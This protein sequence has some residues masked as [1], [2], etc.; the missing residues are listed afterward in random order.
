MSKP[1]RVF[2]RKGLLIPHSRNMRA[3]WN[4]YKRGHRQICL[5][6]N[7][8]CGKTIDLLLYAIDKMRKIPNFRVN[9]YRTEYSTIATTV[10]ETMEHDVFEYPLGDSRNRHPKNPFYLSGGIERP[11]RLVWDNGSSMRFIGLDDKK[12]TRGMAADLSILNEGTRELT[13]EAWVEMGAIQAAGRAGAWIVDGEPFSQRILDTNPDSPLHWI[14][15]LFRKDTNTDTLPDVGTYPLGEKLWLGFST[16]DNP[17]HTDENGV[18]NAL[19]RKKD[20]DLIKTYPEGFERLRMVYSQW[21]AALGLVYSGYK[22]DVYEIDM[23]PKDFADDSTWYMGLDLGGTDPFA[24]C[25]VNVDGDGNQKLFREIFLSQC[26]LDDIETRMWHIIRDIIGIGQSELTIVSD[27]NVPEF[28]QR[29]RENGWHVIEAEKG[30]GS[31]IDRVDLGKK[32]I[33]A[34]KLRVAKDSLLER[35]PNYKGP[36]GFKEEVLGYAYHP[37]EKQELLKNPNL[38]IDKNDHS[39]NAWEYL[40]KHITGEPTPY[41]YTSKVIRF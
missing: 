29:F 24:A 9:W 4:S 15:K 3:L 17:L 6:G 36:Q 22:P 40:N 16:T 1:L 23:N 37:E 2:Y 39:M 8:G 14:Y 33:N 26:L 31:I 35:D 13:S 38:P 21:C 10:V 32:T 11:R 20:E 12:K 5:S 41:D 7:R 19:G 34:G 28:I 18:I 30:A 27:T 25:F